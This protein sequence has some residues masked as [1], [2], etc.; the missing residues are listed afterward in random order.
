MML[1]WTTEWLDEKLI[2]PLISI[3]QEIVNTRVNEVVHEI[4]DESIKIGEGRKKKSRL[5][6]ARLRRDKL[7]KYLDVWW[8]TLEEGV[9]DVEVD[10]ESHTFQRGEKRKKELSNMEETEEE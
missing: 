6:I 1:N 2:T 9:P 8:T 7:L 5:E 10:L 3:G 4:L